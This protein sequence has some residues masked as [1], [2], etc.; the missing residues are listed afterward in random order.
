MKLLVISDT[1]N[2]YENIKLLNEIL[3]DDID[4]IIHLGDCSEDIDE[5][6]RLFNKRV[7]GVR[8]NCDT[9]TN[10]SIDKI[11]YVEGKKIF[12]THG[13]KYDVKN[14]INRLIYTAMENKV[15]IVLFGH[16]HIPYYN[17]IDNI[18]FLNPGSLS[19]PIL[20][21]KSFAI[22]EILQEK[23]AVKLVNMG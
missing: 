13:H 2:K 17:M 4:F 7:I 23:I 12:L 14:S 19:K 22:I 9:R 5:I 21:K 18:H 20:S 1:H 6:E 3:R 16:T 10:L 15:D 8:G 11:E